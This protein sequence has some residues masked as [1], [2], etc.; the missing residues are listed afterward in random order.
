MSLQSV[1]R[2]HSL[3]MICVC[4]S[5]RARSGIYLPTAP[6]LH[7]CL[8][9]SEPCL[10]SFLKAL[11]SPPPTRPCELPNLNLNRRYD[12]LELK[13][14]GIDNIHKVRQALTK[15]GELSMAGK[16]SDAELH[17]WYKTVED[18]KW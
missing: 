7:H 1:A 13:F 17:N 12:F 15:M 10:F 11:E 8:A 14:F 18:T 3:S 16:H 5:W 6:R 2:G 4:V 9:T